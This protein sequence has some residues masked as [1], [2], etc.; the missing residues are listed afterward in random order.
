[1]SLRVA[2]GRVALV[3]GCIALLGCSRGAPEHPETRALTPDALPR[4]EEAAPQ[5]SAANDVAQ[6]AQGAQGPALTLD[7]Q[8]RS[9]PEGLGLSIRN[10]GTEAVALKR[11]LSWLNRDQSLAPSSL[12][13]QLGCSDAPCITLEAGTEWLSPHWLDAPSAERCGTSLAT[14]PADAVA[15]RLHACEGSRSQDIVLP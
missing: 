9:L 8:V 11:S 12:S 7:G 2:V 14:R 4:G 3:S 10:R 1:M 15:L 13:L 6:T 5:A